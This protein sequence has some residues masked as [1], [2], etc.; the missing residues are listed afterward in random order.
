MFSDITHDT[1]AGKHESELLKLAIVLTQRIADINPAGAPP[2]LLK[3]SANVQEVSNDKIIAV[4]SPKQ[5]VPSQ[6]HES[7]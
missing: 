4:L 3:L 2:P 6:G 7:I 5:R 1:R